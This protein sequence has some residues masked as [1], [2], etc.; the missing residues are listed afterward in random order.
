MAIE[1]IGFHV[2]D[3]CQLD[4]DHCLRDPDQKPN[5]ID[6]ALVR[7]AIREARAVYHTKHVIFTGGEP[8]L[9]PDFRGLVDAAVDEGCTWHLVTNARTFQDL[10]RMLAERPARRAG[11]SAVCFS[12]D[13]ASEAVHDGIRE[14]GNYRQV[15]R[16]ASASQAE[17]LPF[18]FQMV[19]NARNV[20]E[21][22]AVGML[23]SELGA[24]R[25]SF[26][27]MQPT[28]THHDKE[29][30]LS[31]RAWRNVVD[32]L[33]RLSAILKLPINLPEGFPRET[34][35]HTCSAFAMSQI[36]VDVRGRLNL[37]CQHSGI[38]SSGEKTDVAGDL[39]ELPLTEAHVGLLDLIHREQREKIAYL[40]DRALEPWDLFA[41]NH[42]LKSFGKPHWTD[43]GTSGAP[44][45]RARWRGAWDKKVR[46]PQ[47][48]P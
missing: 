40:R 15:L 35:F 39:H 23:A 43:E 24:A 26:G 29:L 21:L 16:A 10:L 11:L 34:P 28:G 37:C 12:L 44:A 22:E 27:M 8:T 25:L 5:D 46:L 9:H 6:V 36:H 18:S 33:D 47:V 32:R 3:R 17:G 30:Y 41:C 14:A 38:P 13:G 48:G 4:C 7:S 2:T 20:H 42:C 1:T 31:A 19:V 45:Q